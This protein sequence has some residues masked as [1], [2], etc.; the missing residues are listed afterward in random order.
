MRLLAAALATFATV[1]VS[2]PSPF[3][4][5][6]G[7]SFA[8][9]EV[10]P[11]LAADPKHPERLYAVWQQDRNI[12]AG[13]RG[14]VV[15]RSADSGNTWRRS[16]VPVG[17]CGRQTGVPWPF[18]TDPWV[19]V[20][21]DGRVYVAALGRGIVVVT[22][23]DGGATWTKPVYVQSPNFA[24]KQSLTADPRRA[25]TAYLVWSDYRPTTP[26][27]TEADG[28]L[29]VTHDGGRTWSSPRAILPHGR[30]AGP[31]SSL[32]L[33][34][35]RNGRLYDVA[36][37][38]RNGEPTNATPPHFV[39]HHS[40]D[41]GRTWSGRNDF[42]VGLPARSNGGP[43]IRTSPAVPSFAL[44]DGGVLYG[45]W[46]DSRFSGGR[47]EQL[48][49]STSSDGGATWS[50]PRRLGPARGGAILPVVAAQG[51]G[52]VAI[53]HLRLA[54]TL[55]GARWHVLTSRDR[56]RTFAD[57]T[58]GAPFDLGRAPKLKGDVLVPSGYFLGDYMGAAPLG[59]GRFGELF[60]VT[61][62]APRDPTTVLY[63]AVAS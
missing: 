24:D 30:R 41:G 29:S 8:G 46:Q 52:R 10:E 58:V 43:V 9:S 18:A 59:G 17:V 22:S 32:I 62:A 15:A 48:T 3:A 14:I 53:L 55:R 44:D 2:G 47:V 42:A 61:N 40:D 36:S 19:S 1:H 51:D 13:A 28:M 38:V 63:A 37:W 35:R 25:G 21:A 12:R 60:V 54:T 49:F 27:G 20:G 23:D 6:S 57:R 5:C 39:V 34:D 45:A 16:V 11:S 33:V 56:G 31:L 7:P 26:P 50:A 4:R